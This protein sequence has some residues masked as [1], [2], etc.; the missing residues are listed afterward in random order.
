MKILTILP[1]NLGDVLM[2]LPVLEGLSK[3]YPESEI[4]FLCEEGYEAG[5]EHSSAC[6]KIILFNRKKFKAA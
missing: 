4:H 2:A 6:S 1:N 3:K 5:I